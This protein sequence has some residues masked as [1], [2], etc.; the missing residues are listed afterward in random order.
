VRPHRTQTLPPGGADALPV[1]RR[2]ATL[3]DEIR[4]ALADARERTLG[5]VAPIAEDDLARVHSP[6]MSPLLWDL[7]HIA[8][9]EDLWLCQRAGGLAPLRSDLADVYDAAETPRVDRGDAPYL[10]RDDALEFMQQVR[11]RSLA[12][13]DHTDVSERGDRLN[14]RAF[15]WEMVVQHEH[16]H[17]ETMLQTMQLAEAGVFEAPRPPVGD[18]AGAP[19]G[20]EMIS[21]PAGA[22]GMGDPGRGFSY[23]NER[24]RHERALGAFEID[25]T[26][27]TNGRF[28]RFVAEGGYEC[29]ELWRTEGWHW[30]ERERVQR[31]LY[32]TPDGRERRFDQVVPRDPDL[33]VMHVSW[34]EADAYARWAG[35]RLPTEAEWER[36]AC[37]DAEAGRARRCP[38]GDEDPTRNRA[39]LDQIA[40]GPMAPGALQG[41]TPDGVEAMLGD[42]WEWTA[43]P[44]TGYPGFVAFPY[45]EYSEVFFGDRFRVLRGGSWATRPSVARNTFRNWDLP[46]RR[47][48]FCGFRCARDA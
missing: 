3:L 14:A 11:E 39:N 29:R 19:D 1:E 34:H 20:P 26:P 47:Q 12:V 44:F 13:L 37:W 8:A 45:R 22:F 42:C 43:S 32:W 27:V 30:R 33:P 28:E 38:W 40:F 17:N 46:Q 48:I 31:P 21:I 6:L 36:S 2:G 16:Q 10:R 23:D 4:D 41:A 7:G 24:P 25:R 35:K 15:V 9:C 5:L 18:G